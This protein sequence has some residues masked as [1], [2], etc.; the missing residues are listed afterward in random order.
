MGFDL[1]FPEKYINK[2]NKNKVSGNTMI[3]EAR[4]DNS[5]KVRHK[6]LKGLRS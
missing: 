2:E 5:N 6:H 4:S 3:V 1:W